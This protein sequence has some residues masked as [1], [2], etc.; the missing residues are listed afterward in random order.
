[1]EAFS[2]KRQANSRALL[3]PRDWCTLMVLPFAEFVLG[4]LITLGL[5]TRWALTLGG[6]LIAALIFGTALRSD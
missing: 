6:L 5:F 2:S 1:V 4:D 3:Y